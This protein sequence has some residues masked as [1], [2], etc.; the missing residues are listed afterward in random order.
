MEHMT[1][2]P[3]ITIKKPDGTF[4]KVSLSEFK[5]MQA[6]KKPVD[7]KP[8]TLA[9]HH[10]T[11]HPAGHHPVHIKEEKK[12]EHHATHHPKPMTRED[13]KSPLQEKMPSQS[14]GGLLSS[15]REK[16][17][18]EV[19]KKIGFSVAPDLQGRLKSLVL[20]KLKDIKSEDETREALSRPVKNSGFGLTEIQVDKI[21]KTCQ[22]VL[23]AEKTVMP[24][25]DFKVPPLKGKPPS[26]MA[27]MVEPPELPMVMT[28]PP[29]EK[30]NI[31]I[32]KIN[33]G[34]SGQNIIDN[35]NLTRWGAPIPPQKNKDV[36]S[37]L[38]Q[39]S[40]ASESTF[41]ISDRSVTKQIMQDVSVPEMEMGPVEEFKTLTIA[42]FRRLSS[43]P[44]E[45][46]KRLQQ[47]MSNLQDE[48]F[49]W[50]LEGVA[51]YHTSPLYVEY[52][53]GVAQSLAERKSLASVLAIKNGIKLD[54]VKAIIEM[55]KML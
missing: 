11:H 53:S 8:Q 16:Q 18:E 3:M 44:Q 55:E 24:E 40:I 34:S 1:A 36:I 52:M 41:K 19:L 46:A 39:Q 49:V 32:P 6:E 50:Y 4:A 31:E 26:H 17:V 54:E 12:T 10:T 45:A 22:E 27:L 51:A 28:R 15:N 7:T 48:S 30:K 33:L 35:I 47:K 42:E 38:V 21:I 37:Q 13:S 29:M 23:A 5:K 14:S 2:E 25:S 43:N 20:A 9:P